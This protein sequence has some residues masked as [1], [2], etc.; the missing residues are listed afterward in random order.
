[1]TTDDL[2]PE[3]IEALLA[4]LKAEKEKRFTKKVEAGEVAKV[5]A[6]VVEDADPE[7]AKAAALENHM[8]NNPLDRAKP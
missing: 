4:A 1:M 3:K 7:K 5:Q 6:I 2:S 8:K